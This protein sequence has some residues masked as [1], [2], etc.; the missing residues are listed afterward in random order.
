MKEIQVTSLP[1]A[2]MLT[3][4]II[5][6]KLIRLKFCHSLSDDATTTIDRAG[7]KFCFL[8]SIQLNLPLRV[9]QQAIFK[10]ELKILNRF[11]YSKLSV[12]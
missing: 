2:E 8:C 9:H 12:L 11:I 6:L 5:R 7:T 1:T 10:I 3:I 4:L